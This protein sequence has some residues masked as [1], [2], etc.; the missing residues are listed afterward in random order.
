M[1]HLEAKEH[2]LYKYY[3]NYKRMREGLEPENINEEEEE[4]HK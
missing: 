3:K 4:A 2:P 1:G